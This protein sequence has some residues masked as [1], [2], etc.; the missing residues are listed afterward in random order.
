VPQQPR[1][2]RY[3]VARIAD[4]THDIRRI[5]MEPVDGTPFAF[6]AGQFASVTFGALP[7][8]DYSMASRPDEAM[9][10][11]HIRRVGRDG[12]SVYVS[13]ALALG[14]AVTVE[15]PFGEAVLRREHEGPLIA[16]AGGSGLAPMKSIVETAL[17][18][19]TGQDIR[20][21]FGCR[22]ERDLY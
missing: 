7:P 21:Y 18:L 12:A 5:W 2:F 15:G 16:I 19:G 4:A 6:E 13:Q 11:F 20:L 8:R 9:L 17:A 1:K 14:D 10:E 3:K 22:Q